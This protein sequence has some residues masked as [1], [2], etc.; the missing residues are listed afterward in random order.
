MQINWA[1]AV[2][3]LAS[4]VLCR[5]VRVEFVVQSEYDDTGPMGTSSS[6]TPTDIPHGYQIYEDRVPPAGI[7]F[8]RADAEAFARSADR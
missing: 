6:F 5:R 3:R 7:S 8:H 2:V 1:L 4:P